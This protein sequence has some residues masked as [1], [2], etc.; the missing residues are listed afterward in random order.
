MSSSTPPAAA[1][2]RSRNA[3]AVRHIGH[4]LLRQGG[5]RVVILAGRDGEGDPQFDRFGRGLRQPGGTARALEHGT[6]R[7]AHPRDAAGAI[8]GDALS[9]LRNSA[10]PESAQ[11]P[12]CD[13]AAGANEC[14]RD[15]AFGL[16][17]SIIGLNP[18]GGSK[19]NVIGYS[20]NKPWNES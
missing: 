6:Q 12:V 19:R 2:C 13:V 5:R 16:E 4:R 1:R 8:G 15:D 9:L 7:L 14:G 10:A 17:S 11:P 3:L 18:L 20:P